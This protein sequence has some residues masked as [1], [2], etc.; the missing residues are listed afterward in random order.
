MSNFTATKPRLE[1]QDIL[2][3]FAPP[4]KR[5]SRAKDRLAA[6]RLP[7]ILVLQAV[8]TWRLNDIVN[9]DEALYIHGGHV[10]IGHLLH[11]GTAN[12]ALLRLYGSFFS[13]APNADPVVAAALDSAGGLILVRLFSLCCMLAATV[14]VY[15]MGRHLFNENV[16]LLASL[17]FALTGSVQFVGKL[18][19]YDAPCLVLVGLAA[20]LAV[21][22]RSIAT[23]P[24]IGALL[25]AAAVT[26]YAGLALAPFVLLMT[27][28]TVLTAEGR[29]WRGNFPRAVLRGGA[30]MLVI[31]GLLLG[32]Y[33]LW[34]SGIELLSRPVDQDLL[35]GCGEL[36][37]SCGQ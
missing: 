30:A 7:L 23:A 31:A 29:P 5:T 37:L 8:L 9:D 34:G 10:V 19:T 27:F 36:V 33:H 4:A 18:G 14:C 15:K 6:Y 21:T 25:A 16:A 1:W 32:G 12:A 11:G 28:L 2:L 24:I 26:K 20:A 22:K 17:I 3:S 35:S 13:G